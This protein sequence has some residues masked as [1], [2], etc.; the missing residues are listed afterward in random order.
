MKGQRLIGPWPFQ[1]LPKNGRRR[2]AC[3]LLPPEVRRRRPT[4][5]T[6]VGLGTALRLLPPWVT[7]PCRAAAFG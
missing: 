1:G 3:D 7:L 4:Q 5:F 2:P 6:K